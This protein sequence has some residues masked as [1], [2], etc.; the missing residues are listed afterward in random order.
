[1]LFMQKISKPVLLA[2]AIISTIACS[3]QTVIKT[4][5]SPNPSLDYK[6]LERI[7]TMVK[8]YINKGWING[9]VTIVVKDGQ[10]VQYKGYGYS[11]VASKKPMD[12]NSIFRIASQTKA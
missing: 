4:S 1:M 11:D 9:V 8:G 7:D 2:A 10:V 5:G 3:A 12:K 6:R